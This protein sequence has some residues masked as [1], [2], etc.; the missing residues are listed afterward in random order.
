MRR[1]YFAHRRAYFP[2]LW[3]WAVLTVAL[4]TVLSRLL[5]PGLLL[6]LGVNLVMGAG[7]IYL[8]VA[9]WRWRNPAISSEEY[10]DDMRKAATWN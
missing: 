8:R 5:S 9:V 7:V 3:P 6:T 10:L 1:R 4:D 2:R